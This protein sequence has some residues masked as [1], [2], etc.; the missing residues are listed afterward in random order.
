MHS[1]HSL[2]TALRLCIVLFSGVLII[3]LCALLIFAVDGILEKKW[4]PILGVCIL[5]VFIL[6]ILFVMVR[7]PQDQKEMPF[8]VSR[9]L[10]LVFFKEK[11]RLI[12][13]MLRLLSSLAWWYS[14]YSSQMSQGF[15][16]F[17]RPKMPNL[18]ISL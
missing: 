8:K 2:S 1:A 14:L 4:P 11:S 3:A 16:H 9:T 12:L 15:S 18:V 7:Q 6:V 5:G 17:S 10:V 13:P